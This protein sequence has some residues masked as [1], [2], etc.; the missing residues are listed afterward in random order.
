MVE[1]KNDERLQGIQIRLE[2][3]KNVVSELDKTI[4]DQEAR[5][6]FLSLAKNWLSDV[7]ALLK[8]AEQW[9]IEASS[10]TLTL[11]ERH[12]LKVK[13]AVAKYGPRIRIIGG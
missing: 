8:H 4:E 7:E 11:A 1:I 3:M 10:F 9:R 12:L 2:A 5:D 13:Q 6:Y